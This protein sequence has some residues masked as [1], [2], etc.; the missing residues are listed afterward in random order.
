MVWQ[1]L[2]PCFFQFLS[3]SFRHGREQP[4]AARPLW[5]QIAA[6]IGSRSG[7]RALAFLFHPAGEMNM[8]QLYVTTPGP[9]RKIAPSASCSNPIRCR[10]LSDFGL[11]WMILA[12]V[13]YII[14]MCLQFHI[15]L[16]N[17]I[18]RWHLSHILLPH[19]RFCLG[20]QPNAAFSI[21]AM[22]QNAVCTMRASCLLAMHGHVCSKL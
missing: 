6:C 20:V 12:T 9:R 3:C 21:W 14:C 4:G 17:A 19:C 8:T 10:T 22:A 2:E 15:F 5:W 1:K 11:S 13:V 7:P 18:G 16:C